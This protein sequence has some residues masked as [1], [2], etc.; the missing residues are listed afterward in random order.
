MQFNIRKLF[1]RRS[2]HNKNAFLQSTDKL[3]LP[4]IQVILCVVQ[5][6]ANSYC[7][8]FPALGKN[9]IHDGSLGFFC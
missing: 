4:L 1:L 2:E 5:P 3:D 7:V 8:A 6:Q 9:I